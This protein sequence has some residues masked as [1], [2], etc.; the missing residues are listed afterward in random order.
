LLDSFEPDRVAKQVLPSASAD[1]CRVRGGNPSQN[2]NEHGYST[3]EALPADINRDL[4]PGVDWKA[5]A[6]RYLEACVKKQ[7][8]RESVE[9]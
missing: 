2:R 8:S 3:K 4:P 7:A 5:G 1:Q 9:I 6:R